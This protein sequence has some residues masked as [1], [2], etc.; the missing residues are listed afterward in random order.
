M[1]SAV[2]K[3]V[4]TIRKVVFG[5]VG[6]VD[7]KPRGRGLGNLFPELP[8][9][10]MLPHDLCDGLETF[11]RSFYCGWKLLGVRVRRSG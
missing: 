11:Q 1:G 8:T 3:G 9:T 5:S 2:R 6:V 10:T 4:A 7:S